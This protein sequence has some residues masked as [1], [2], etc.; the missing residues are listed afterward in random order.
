MLLI[1]GEAGQGKSTLVA[2][3]AQAGVRPRV[4]RGCSGTSE[5]DLA[6][7]YQLFAR[8]SDTT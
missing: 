3:A 1:S 8:H 2:E 7:P 6:T 4:L 5:E